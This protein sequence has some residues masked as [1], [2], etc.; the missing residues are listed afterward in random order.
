MFLQPHIYVNISVSYLRR[1]IAA[2]SPHKLLPSQATFFVD[3]AREWTIL[4][5][6]IP[7]SSTILQILHLRKS[8]TLKIRQCSRFPIEETRAAIPCPTSGAR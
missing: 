4:E 2:R 5:L 3:G 6:S 8:P 1:I 7:A